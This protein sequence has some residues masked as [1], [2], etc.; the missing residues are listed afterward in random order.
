MATLRYEKAPNDLGDS[1]KR[2]IE[3]RI[4]TGSFLRAVLEND[5]K[6]ACGR[7]DIYNQRI[8]FEIVYWLYN[9]A[10]PDCWGSPEKV[11][12]WLKGDE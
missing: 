6:E 4:P 2:Y 5:L 3:L 11:K 10:P 1:F 12:A 9:E 8:L 7:A